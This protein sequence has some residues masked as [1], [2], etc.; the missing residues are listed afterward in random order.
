METLVMKQ[1]VNASKQVVL[2]LPKFQEGDEVEV[3][4]VVHAASSSSPA[5]HSVFDMAQWA[6]QWETDLGED[7]H[8]TDVA[9]F[10]GRD[11]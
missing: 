4:M 8:S 3:I 9:S 11:F 7:V 5:K 6:K 1:K 10:T 2:E